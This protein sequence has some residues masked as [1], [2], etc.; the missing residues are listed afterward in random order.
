MGS[1]N[2][3][4]SCVELIAIFI[5]HNYLTKATNISTSGADKSP[6]NH[7]MSSGLNCGH[8]WIH[9]SKDGNLSFNYAG[10]IDKI[11]SAWIIKFRK[12]HK[13]CKAPIIFSGIELML[14]FCN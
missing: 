5:H 10:V 13:G 12:W 6:P 3:C 9:G 8:P 2:V 11:T 14:C 1:W 7:S 4:R